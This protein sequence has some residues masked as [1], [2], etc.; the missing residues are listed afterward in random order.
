MSPGNEATQRF[1]AAVAALDAEIDWVRLGR[2]YCEGDARTFFDEGLRASILQTGLQLADDVARALVPGPACK[3]LYLGA[4]VA[5]IVPIL[6]ER[7]VLGRE[8]AWLNLPGD[9]TDEL[10]RALTLVGGRLGLDLPRPI[11]DPIESIEPRS[12]DHLWMVSVLTDPD[13]F[14]ALHDELY[15]RARGPLATGRGVL[16]EERARA[17]RL[18]EQLLARA[19]TT[20][21]LTTTDEELDLLRPILARQSLRLDARRKGRLS[22]IVGDRISVGRVRAP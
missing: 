10:A 12:C 18:V 8:V 17:E 6:A 9:E 14:P 19:T 22:A 5:E 2:A 20:F 11:T 7:L 21:A 4:A 1:G 3:S 16:T 13:A 15:E